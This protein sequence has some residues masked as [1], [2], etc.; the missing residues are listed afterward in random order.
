MPR[1]SRSYAIGDA[2]GRVTPTSLRRLRRELKLEVMK[3]WFLENFED[4]VESTP[5]DSSEGGYLYIYGGPYD[6]YEELSQEFGGVVPD[7]LIENLASELSDITTEWTGNTNRFIPDDYIYQSQLL[8]SSAYETL[9]EA[10]Q[11]IEQL[12]EANIDETLRQQLVKAC[13]ASVVAAMEA[14]LSDLFIGKVKSTPGL[15]IKLVQTTPEFKQ[16]KFALADIH[17]EL[18]RIEKTV[19][20]HL[21]GV[22]WHNL[23]RVKEMYQSVLSVAF[24][25]NLDKLY[26]A[27][28]QR[29]DIVHRNGK[30]IDGTSGTWTKDDVHNL[31]TQVR[32]LANC[33]E[34]ELLSAGTPHGAEADWDF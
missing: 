33:I 9:E 17:A 7:S 3:T 16:Q 13:F 32:D 10:L 30:L 31:I 8:T 14:Y 23:A 15:M 11:N 4:P 5:Y 20:T 27:V 29:H 25:D 6:P 21:S 22:L 19:S 28:H 2:E 1:R 24:P 12:V 34:Q 18:E 26:R